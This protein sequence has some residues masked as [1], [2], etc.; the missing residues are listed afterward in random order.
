MN[1]LLAKEL[2]SHK[3]KRKHDENRHYIDYYLD[4]IEKVSTSVLLSH[5]TNKGF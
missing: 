3:V 2:E 1:A 5:F 4:E